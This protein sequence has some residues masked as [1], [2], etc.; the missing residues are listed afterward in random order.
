[1]R[2]GELCYVNSVIIIGFVIYLRKC[3]YRRTL[4]CALNSTEPKVLACTEKERYY[5]VLPSRVLPKQA[6][7]F[8]GEGHIASAVILGHH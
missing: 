8:K 6:I 4:L 3:T 5:P 2:Y 1:M 7:S